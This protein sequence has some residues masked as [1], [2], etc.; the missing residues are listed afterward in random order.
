MDDPEIVAE[1]ASEDGE[2]SREE[3]LQKLNDIIAAG[4]VFLQKFGEAINEACKIVK[5]LGKVENKKNE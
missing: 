4:L 3:S 2:V 5:N 1:L